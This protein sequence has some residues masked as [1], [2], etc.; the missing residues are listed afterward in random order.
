MRK[1]IA[2]R[3]LNNFINSL[4]ASFGVSVLSSGLT[5]WPSSSKQ[6]LMVPKWLP[7]HQSTDSDSSLHKKIGRGSSGG[8]YVREKGENIFLS[9][10][11]P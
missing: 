5:K 8:F 6:S 4:S 3:S 11:S 9:P 1:V 2:R 10:R 7:Q